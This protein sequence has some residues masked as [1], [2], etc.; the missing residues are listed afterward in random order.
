[1]HDG[2]F[3]SVR[4]LTRSVLSVCFYNN[5]SKEKQHGSW[6]ISLH[7]SCKVHA[8]CFYETNYQ[9]E[10]KGMSIAPPLN[11][12]E[13]ASERTLLL[14]H[15]EVRWSAETSQTFSLHRSTSLLIFAN[16]SSLD[17]R[18]FT[19]MEEKIDQEQNQKFQNLLGWVRFIVN[20]EVSLICCDSSNSFPV[21][22]FWFSIFILFFSIAEYAQ[23][24]Y[25]RTRKSSKDIS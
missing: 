7:L 21:G 24:I 23:S 8:P 14:D 11:L 13:M 9:F 4:C 1:M 18:R 25:E 6:R 17:R 15:E 3:D 5:I 12:E 22:L 2:G 20:L 19:T 10:P 16:F